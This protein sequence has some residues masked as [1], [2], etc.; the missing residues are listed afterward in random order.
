MVLQSTLTGTL[1]MQGAPRMHSG[2]PGGP[3]GRNMEIGTQITLVEVRV[4]EV[5][6]GGRAHGRPRARGRPRPLQKVRAVLQSTL[7]QQHKVQNMLNKL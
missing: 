2:A 7:R 6:R 3:E 4:V 1:R 5:R